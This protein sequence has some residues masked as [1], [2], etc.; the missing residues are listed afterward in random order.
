MTA[1]V[2]EVVVSAN[3][4]GRGRDDRVRQ[5]GALRQRNLGKPAF[6]EIRRA[7]RVHRRQHR[8]RNLHRFLHRPEHQRHLEVVRLARLQRE[9]V[10]LLAEISVGDDEDVVGWR[11]PGEHEVAIRSRRRRDRRGQRC[12][13]QLHDRTGH[14]GAVGPGGHGAVNGGLSLCQHTGGGHEQHDEYNKT[15][16][17]GTDTHEDTPTP[18]G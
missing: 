2:D 7:R 5:V 11:E 6:G 18:R 16:N 10:S 15:T 9:P 4:P 13:L 12:A 1:D 8:R 3:H 14:R 17:D